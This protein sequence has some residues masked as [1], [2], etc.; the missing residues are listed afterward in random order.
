MR[1]RPHL[2]FIGCVAVEWWLEAFNRVESDSLVR[3][4]F[5][6]TSDA[7]LF[8]VPDSLVPISRSR[9]GIRR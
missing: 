8:C 1:E 3:R 9:R 6:P 4:N 2:S 5:N 7:A